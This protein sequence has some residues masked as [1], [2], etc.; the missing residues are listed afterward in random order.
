MEKA[1]CSCLP[2]LSRVRRPPGEE[3]ASRVVCAQ[4]LALPGGVDVVNLVDVGA[5]VVEARLEAE[6]D[7]A[8]NLARQQLLLGGQVSH[9]SSSGA[10]QQQQ[11][12]QVQHVKVHVRKMVFFIFFLPL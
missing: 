12:Q 11:Q 8:A 10:G 2:V 9:R 6:V 7:A 5:V 4:P 3:H 1:L